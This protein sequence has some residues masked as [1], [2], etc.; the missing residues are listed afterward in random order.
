MVVSC[1]R[2]EG[3]HKHKFLNFV[4]SSDINPPQKRAFS[5]DGQKLGTSFRTL[6]MRLLNVFLSQYLMVAILDSK[7]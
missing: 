7:L 2:G 3:H 4:C 1:V 5:L 6:C